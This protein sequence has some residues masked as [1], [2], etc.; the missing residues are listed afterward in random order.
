MMISASDANEERRSLL[1]A[2][3]HAGHG[4]ARGEVP[5][6]RRGDINTSLQSS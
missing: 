2:L 3:L 6:Q 4:F 5:A 1:P